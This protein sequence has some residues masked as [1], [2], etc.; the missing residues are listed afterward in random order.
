MN[1]QKFDRFLQSLPGWRKRPHRGKV[2]RL[3]EATR[4][5]INRMIEDGATY[6]AIIEKLRQ[7]SPAQLPY[8]ISEMNLSNWR[9]SGY[10]EWQEE[11]FWNSIQN[12]APIESD[13]IALN[14]T[15]S[16]QLKVK[17]I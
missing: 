7:S 2:A 16:D 12:S 13:Q 4:A 11:Q 5:Q 3:P 9:R 10:A 15:K 6:R 17:N 8:P 14:R 1:Q